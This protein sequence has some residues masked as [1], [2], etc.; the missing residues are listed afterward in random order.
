M[1][2]LVPCASPTRQY[3]ISY[4]WICDGL[5]GFNRPSTSTTEKKYFTI[6]HGERVWRLLAYGCV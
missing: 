5:R 6:I 4:T 2:I 1:K 3:I